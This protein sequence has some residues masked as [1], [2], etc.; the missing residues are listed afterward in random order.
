MKNRVN[1]LLSDVKNPELKEKYRELILTLLEKGY[2]PGLEGVPVIKSGISHI[3]GEEGTL[4]YRGYPVQELAEYCTYEDICYLLIHGDLPLL[5]ERVQLRSELFAKKDLSESVS[6]VIM[7]M[8]ENLH[9]MYM[10]SSSVLL[11][12]AEDQECACVND[13]ILN[14]RRGLNLIG[15]LPS[16]IGVFRNKD[17]DFA[18]GKEFDSFAQ[19][20]LYVFNP[21]LAMDRNWVNVFEKILILH[22]DHTMNNS[23]FSVRAV[24]SSLAS[25]YASIASAI[26][27]LSGPLHGGANE[28]TIKMFEEIGSPDNVEAFIEQKLARKEKIMGIGHRVYKTYDPRSLYMKNKILPMVFGEES[29]IEVDEEMVNLYEIAR[30]IE[31]VVLEKLSEKKL[32]PNVDFWSGLILKALGIEPEYFTTIFALGRILGW[33]SHWIEHMKVRN[34]IFRPEQLYNGIGVRHIILDTEEEAASTNNGV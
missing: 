24:A 20:C 16:I 12:Q 33:V 28:R 4:T 26:N 9:P 21:E 22:A 10:L 3:D 29:I 13:Y 17:A 11:L 27:S 23:T 8:D 18:A 5:K 32:Y 19:Y 1:E 7:E 2:F 15:K 14:Y 6:K 31:Q 34:K 30:K 25:I